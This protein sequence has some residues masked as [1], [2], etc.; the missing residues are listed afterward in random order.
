MEAIIQKLTENFFNSLGE[1]GSDLNKEV[2]F[3]GGSVWIED[4]DEESNTF[5]VCVD[6]RNMNESPNVEHYLSKELSARIDIAEAI[7]NVERDEEQAERAEEETRRCLC[8]I[9]GWSY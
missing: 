8:D 5:T 7:Y 1:F 4:Y 9:N 2:T 3:N 6:H